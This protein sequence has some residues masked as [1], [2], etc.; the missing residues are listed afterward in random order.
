M[1]TNN[2]KKEYSNGEITVIWESG[3]CQ[4]SGNCVRNLPAV[5]QSRAQPWIKMDAATSDEIINTVALCP[6]GALR[7]K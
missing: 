1:D 7:I 4:H 2:I 6:S 3:K 5:F